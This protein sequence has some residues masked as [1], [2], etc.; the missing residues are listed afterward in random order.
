MD[1]QTERHTDWQLR[2]TD[3]RTDRQ[4]VNERPYTRLPFLKASGPT[5]LSAFDLS[6][7][8]QTLAHAT[9]DPQRGAMEVPKVKGRLSPVTLQTVVAH[10]QWSSLSLSLPAFQPLRRER[11]GCC[12]RQRSLLLLASIPTVAAVFYF[13]TLCSNLTRLLSPLIHWRPGV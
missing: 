1:G 9:S 3:R 2:R 10:A 13:K 4:A 5:C 8:A 11:H 7:A 6:I 12:R